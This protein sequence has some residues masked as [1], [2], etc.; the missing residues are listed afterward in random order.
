MLICRKQVECDFPL[1]WIPG[2]GGRVASSEQPRSGAFEGELVAGVLEGAVFQGKATTADAEIELIPH[3]G[4]EGNFLFECL[5]PGAADFLPVFLGRD[6]VVG[7]VSEGFFDFFEREPEALGDFDKGE[8]A[9]FSPWKAPVVSGVAHGTDKAFRFVE[10]DRG[11]GDAAP[12]RGFSDGEQFFV[13]VV[14]GHLDTF[15]SSELEVND[16]RLFPTNKPRECSKIRMDANFF[17]VFRGQAPRAGRMW[18]EARPLRHLTLLL[19]SRG[20]NPA[21]SKRLARRSNGQRHA[22]P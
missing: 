4:G 17:D 6:A 5:V 19:L 3:A 21:S 7:D 13:F 22:S 18:G 1:P 11:N 8:D 2:N 9:E 20:G 14:A 12:F 10:V 16:G 15:T